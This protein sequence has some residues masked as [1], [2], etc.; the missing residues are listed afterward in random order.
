P[1]RIGNGAAEQTQL[2]VYG[3]L[4]DAVET[5]HDGVSEFESSERDFL[6]DAVDIAARRWH[7][8]DHGI[9]EMRG[10]PRHFVHSKV[11]CWVALDRGI[12]L[13]ALLGADAE[14]V[15][16]WRKVADEL[17]EE[18]MHRGVDPGRGCFRQHYDT[19]EVD[20]SLLKLPLV[21]F[22]DPKHPVMMATV[23]AIQHDLTV[24]HDGFIRRYARHVDDGIVGPSGSQHDSDE[25]VFLVASC[26]LVEN[27]V[28]Q[29]R[30]EEASALFDRV[31]TTSNDLDLFAEEFDVDSSSMLG[32]FPQAFTHLGMLLAARRLHD[33]HGKPTRGTSSLRP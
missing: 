10:E 19:D 32:N 31:A 18:V 20:A 9:W 7:E 6:R 2:D 17:R 21:G 28:L 23:S 8:S 33:G 5:W 26:W 11:M 22:I 25:G 4:L 24:G 14:H 29:D 1:V 16:S 30:Y 27:L 15:A 12:S 13:G 3:H